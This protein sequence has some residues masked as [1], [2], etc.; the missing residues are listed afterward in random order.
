MKF[1]VSWSLPHDT[2][3]AAVANFLKA[4]GM[5]PSNVKLVGRWHGMSG[6]GV[7][8]VETTDP[9]ACTPGWRNGVSTCRSRRRRSS[10]TRTLARCSPP[11]TSKVV[12]D[13][14]ARRGPDLINARR[15][16]WRSA[17]IGTG[18]K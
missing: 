17:G 7:A 13:G 4:G 5:P 15:Y 14:R 9:K 3:R 18:T 8:V 1:M 16:C 2:Y 10:R 12:P 11:C 6:K